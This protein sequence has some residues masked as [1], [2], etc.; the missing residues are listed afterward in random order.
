MNEIIVESWND[1]QDRLFENS[2]NESIK[3]YRSP[4]AFRGL[5]D[6]TYPLHT[7]LRR[8]GGDFPTLEHY[9]LRNFK[10]YA[11]RD[12]VEKDSIWHWLSID[13]HHG[14]PTRLL[15]WTYS[16]FIASHFVTENQ[17]KYD[18]D[19][20]IWTVNFEETNNLLPDMLESHALF[21]TFG[22]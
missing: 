8:L 10:K 1:L 9:M 11:H 4:Y 16:P 21:T 17:D 20:I 12:V 22:D 3:R 19:G 5:S 2:W 15:N 18:V 13:Q 14:L 6:K 7:S